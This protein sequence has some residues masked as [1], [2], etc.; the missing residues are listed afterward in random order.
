M[1]S[2]Y[3]HIRTET[4]DDVAVVE[5]LESRI[6]D[7]RVAE[8]MGKE[9]LTAVQNSGATRV[10]VDM[11][12]VQY[13]SSVGYMPFLSLH[14]QVT[15]MDGTMVMCSMS[16]FIKEIFEKTRLLINPRSKQSLFHNAD[17][18]TEAVGIANGADR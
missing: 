18:V 6:S 15:A 8:T 11:S 5:I 16:T 2:A 12:A 3:Q 1:S 9:M 14:G 13:M 7:Y 10:V 4:I 17:S